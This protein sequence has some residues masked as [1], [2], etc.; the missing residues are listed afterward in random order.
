MRQA[1]RQARLDDVIE[2]MPEQYETSVGER[3]IRLSGGQR[4]RLGIA[5]AFYKRSKIIIFDEA[6]S[7]LDIS[8]EKKVMD[9]IAG[10]KN[11]V[12]LIIIAHRLSTLRDCDTIIELENGRVLRVGS[13]EEIIKTNSFFDQKLS[14]KS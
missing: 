4:Q 12:T 10:L 14:D 2:A 5:R 11:D 6:T 7:S 1:A 9:S 8:T 3:G 13:F